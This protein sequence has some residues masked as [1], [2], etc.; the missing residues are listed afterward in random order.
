MPEP[1]FPRWATPAARSVLLMVL[2]G[3]VVVPGAMM[4]WVRLPVST[5]QGRA[6]P[7]PIPFDHRLHAGDF[8]ID[9]RYCHATAESQASAGVPATEICVSCHQSVW[10]QGPVFEPV[11]RSLATGRPIAWRRV[12]LMPGYVYFDHAAHTRHGIGCETCHGRVDRM[13]RMA[14]AAPLTM[15]WCL[16]CHQ[17]PAQHVRP[18]A[19]VT[20]MGWAPAGQQ[21]TAAAM[22]ARLARQYGV[23][24]KTACV[25]C[26]R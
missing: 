13:A 10:L 2:L 22:R 8:R 17:S 11:R 14:Q 3:V 24:A 18:I 15:G 26:H 16:D 6:P 4:A 9:C 7:Q 23:Q 19:A 5:G 20:A 25:T 1:L 12:H 21:A